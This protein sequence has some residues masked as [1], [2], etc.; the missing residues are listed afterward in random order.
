[1]GKAIGEIK[2]ELEATGMEML[3]KAMEEYASDERAGVQKLL[4]Q[5]QKRIDQYTKECER[6]DR[7]LEF[8]RKFGEYDVVCGIDEVGRGPLA[9][10]VVAACVV[11][12][13]DC[14]IL[15][16]N[17][18]KQLSEKK[19]EE[20]YPEIIEKAVGFGV[21]CISH[22]TIDEINI[23]QATYAAMRDAIAQMAAKCGVPDVLLNDAV[24]I[25]GV[26]QLFP[27]N[28]KRILQVPI[29]KGDAK[30]LSIA[31]ASVVAKVTRDH[32][33]TEF[34]RIYPGYGFAQNKGY[35]SSEHIE[36]LKKDGPCPIHRRTFIRNFCED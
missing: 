18:S 25:P 35:G 31:A 11:L 9:G 7:M 6:V 20:L 30:S 4:M 16:L 34:D 5:A 28:Q 24:T 15:Y 21:G 19:R 26:D 3:P 1:M 8:E 36:K 32:M 14:R 33:M 10:P 27:G 2:K 12:P 13:K 23:L 29:V 17:D 22:T